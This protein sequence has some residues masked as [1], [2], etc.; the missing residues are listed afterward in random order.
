MPKLTPLMPIGIALAIGG[1]I[2]IG[3]R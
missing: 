2:T 3:I 1:G